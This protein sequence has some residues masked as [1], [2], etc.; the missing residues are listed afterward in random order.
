MPK[1]K[2]RS[3]TDTF[4]GATATVQHQETIKHLRFELEQIKA[5]NS[6]LKEKHLNRL[7]EEL[8]KHSGEHLLN[9]DQLRPSIQARQTFSLSS[10]RRRAESFKRYGQ[11]T[12]IIVVPIADGIYEIEDGELRWRAA[13]LLVTE[14]MLEWKQLKVVFAPPPQPEEDL[15]QR[16]LIHHLHRE[17]LNALDRMEAVIKYITQQVELF[18]QESLQSSQKQQFTQAEQIK[19]LIRNLDYRFKKNASD[20]AKLHQLIEKSQHE[21]HEQIKSFN[22][23][24]LQEKVLLALVELQINISS[25]AANDLPM[26]SLPI[27]LKKSI[28]RKGL[29][30]HHALAITK[31][32]ATQLQVS[33][34][35]AIRKRQEVVEQ[36]IS[37][38]LSLKATRELVREILAESGLNQTKSSPKT[39]LIKLNTLLDE[40][41]LSDFKEKDLVSL[42]NALKS[43]IK[44]V[45]QLLV[46]T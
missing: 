16:S 14:G 32:S 23:P 6:S 44:E 2:P 12:P 33:E 13:Q 11:K 27:D 46:T 4:A 18:S 45:E 43:K 42:Q 28:R 25:L 20:K 26:L 1:L 10:I 9:I 35:L 37:N 24:L 17:D 8:T 34:E 36:V 22:L 29:A 40:I 3:L 39:M 21:Q 15:H 30:C 38:S 5:E 7:R 31:L 41:P 19:K